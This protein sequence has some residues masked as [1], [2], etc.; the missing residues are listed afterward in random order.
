MEWWIWPVE[1]DQNQIC[2]RTCKNCIDEALCN[3]HACKKIVPPSLRNPI[4]TGFVWFV[5][6]AKVKWNHVFFYILSLSP[7]FTLKRVSP[8]ANLAF[9]NGTSQ[10]KKL[11]GEER[12]KEE[13][14]KKKVRIISIW[15][16]NY[17]CSLFQKKLLKSVWNVKFLL[18]V[19]E[20]SYRHLSFRGEYQTRWCNLNDR[21][22]S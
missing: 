20:S 9:P 15:F 12:K 22:R 21:I 11:Y 19:R 10:F 4:F 14:K 3:L 8:P 6:Q 7:S 2:P 5:K 13:E 17:N 1:R 18:I 16:E